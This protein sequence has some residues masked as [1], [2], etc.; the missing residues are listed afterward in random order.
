MA[1]FFQERFHIEQE[2]NADKQTVDEQEALTP[3]QVETVVKESAVDA[4]SEQPSAVD[5]QYS[6]GEVVKINE[7]LEPVVAEQSPT[8]DSLLIGHEDEMTT[9]LDFEK[10]FTNNKDGGDDHEAHD[11]GMDGDEVRKSEC[12]EDSRSLN[13]Q[14]NKEDRSMEQNEDSLKNTPIRAQ[15]RLMQPPKRIIYSSAMSKPIAA[16]SASEQRT[17]RPPASRVMTRAAAKES[18][19]KKMTSRT[20]SQPR[21]TIENTKTVSQ[22]VTP[23]I[24][25]KVVTVSSKIGSFTDHKPQGGNVRIFSENRTYNVPSKIGSLHNV[26]HTPGGGKVQIENRKLDFKEKAAPRIDAKSDY[27]PPM[28]EKKIFDERIRYVSTNRRSNCGSL[29]NMSNE[30]RSASRTTIDVLDL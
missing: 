28:P 5:I 14:L 26:T 24:Y 17:I 8:M 11:Y 16:S 6:S 20:Q 29:G 12:T 1:L 27:V 23:K 30:S 2:I 13:E 7:L 18:V 19:L 10:N 15:S 9:M 4:C 22:P 3:P 25:R 21:P